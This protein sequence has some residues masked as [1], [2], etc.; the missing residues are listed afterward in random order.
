MPDQPL[1]ERRAPP[2]F[3][4]ILTAHLHACYVRRCVPDGQGCR[5]LYERSHANVSPKVPRR[6]SGSIHRFSLQLVAVFR[7]LPG[8]LQGCR[9]HSTQE[10][11]ASSLQSLE[12]PTDLKPVDY[13]SETHSSASGLRLRSLGK[14]NV[15]VRRMRTRFGDR[16]FS[17]SGPRCWN[18]LPPYTKL[19]ASLDSFKS[20]LKSC[21]I[22]YIYLYIYI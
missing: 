1:T 5:G 12:L 6:P 14:T 21:P 16:A 13:C 20:K 10:A 17:V 3:R 19:A 8:E 2:V 11:D 7:C 22:H 4:D 18:S 15:R 9:R